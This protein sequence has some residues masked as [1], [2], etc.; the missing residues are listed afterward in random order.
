[1][2]NKTLFK[3]S[4]AC[5]LMGIL[6]IVYISD[7][8]EAP[9]FNIEE[10]TKEKIDQEIRIKGEIKNF[11]DLPS[12]VLMEVEDKT[13]TITVMFF[14]EKNVTIKKGQKIE[15]DGKLVEYED[16]LEI[17]ADSIYLRY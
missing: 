9:L 12:L 10:L 14:K 7:K 1:M 6:L 8:I 2:D 4:L 16:K 5:S 13:G 15:V 11:N 17:E 3:I